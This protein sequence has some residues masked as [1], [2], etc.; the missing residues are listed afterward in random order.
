MRVRVRVPVG[1]GV[2]VDVH[3]CVC[4]CVRV[5][6]VIFVLC[7]IIGVLISN[8]FMYVSLRFLP[9]QTPHNNPGRVCGDRD[10]LRPTLHR[11]ACSLRQTQTQLLAVPLA[12]CV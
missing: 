9:P 6:A 7:I 5:S 8:M 2:G 10:G 12:I 4:V 1:V 11:G 3:V